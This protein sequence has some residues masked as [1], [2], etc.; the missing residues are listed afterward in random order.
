MTE[1]QRQQIELDSEKMLG[2]EKLQNIL[3]SEPFT[4]LSHPL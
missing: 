2:F 3:A 1:T 4:Y